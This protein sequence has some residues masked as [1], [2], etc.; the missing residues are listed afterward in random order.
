[1]LGILA[2]GSS[3]AFAQTASLSFERAAYVTCREA[4]ILPPD[5]R[6]VVTT[7][8]TLAATLLAGFGKPA[9]PLLDGGRRAAQVSPPRRKGLR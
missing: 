8:P 1:M 9:L 5:Q 7:G 3:V 4:H 6:I 2:T